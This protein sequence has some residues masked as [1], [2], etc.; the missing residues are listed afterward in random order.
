MSPAH[1]ELVTLSS[2]CSSPSNWS[3]QLSHGELWQCRDN[4]KPKLP[5]NEGQQSSSGWTGGLLPQWQTSALA[6]QHG[7]GVPGTAP[8]RK[9]Q[10]SH[11]SETTPA[12]PRGSTATLGTPGAGRHCQL[13]A[14]ATLPDSATNRNH[15]KDSPENTPASAVRQE[16]QPTASAFTAVCFSG[17]LRSKIEHFAL[18]HSGLTFNLCLYSHPSRMR[19]TCTTS[20]K[21]Q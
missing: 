21:I 3:L 15:G 5:G 9:D 11:T 16:T 12:S 17:N 8:L 7:Q 1:E 2:A 10:E 6:L 14:M 13:S 20:Q 18:I 4:H 19:Q